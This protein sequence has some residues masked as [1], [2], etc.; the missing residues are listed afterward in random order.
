MLG[1]I[2]GNRC[3]S[4]AVYNCSRERFSSRAGT[5]TRFCLGVSGIGLTVHIQL[6]WPLLS[7][8]QAPPPRFQISIR[9]WSL[10]AGIAKINV[11]A[12][13]MITPQSTP[14]RNILL[15][16]FPEPITS[17]AI[18]A[19]PLS[20]YPLIAARSSRKCAGKRVVQAQ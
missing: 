14:I 11:I 18:S 19:T 7:E 17:L 20:L 12:A 10:L 3:A 1:T 5:I 8:V 4:A 16:L 9:Q 15:G 2:C 6:M 13:A